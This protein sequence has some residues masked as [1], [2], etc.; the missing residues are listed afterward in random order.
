MNKQRSFSDPRF[1][2]IIR[3]YNWNDWINSKV[4][5]SIMILI[6]P[7]GTLSA[8]LPVSTFSFS[9]FSHFFPSLLCLHSLCPFF[10]LCLPSSASKSS[11]FSSFLCPDVPCPFSLSLCPSALLLHLIPSR[12]NELLDPRPDTR[13]VIPPIHRPRTMKLP[14]ST[15]STSVSVM[16][17]TRTW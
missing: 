13:E 3:Q 16:K 15:S 11:S 14:L 7:F 2:C 1:M 8:L 9:L 17:G 12:P 10:S 6:P 5:D 4:S